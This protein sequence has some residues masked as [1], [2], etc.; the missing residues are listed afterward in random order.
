MSVEKHF[1]I[2]LRYTQSTV[3]PAFSVASLVHEV[4]KSVANYVQLSSFFLI[5]HSEL[6]IVTPEN[7]HQVRGIS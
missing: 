7:W 6:F 1:S 3:F 5:L 2:F 4:I